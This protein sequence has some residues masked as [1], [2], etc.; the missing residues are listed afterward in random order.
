MA[1]I[2]KLEREVASLNP[3]DL[4]AFRAWFS[5]YDDA[6]WDRQLEADVARGALDTAADVALAQHRAGHSRPL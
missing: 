5:T 3:R 4:A 1:N 2:D 6:A